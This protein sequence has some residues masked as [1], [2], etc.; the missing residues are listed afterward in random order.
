MPLY[1]GWFFLTF[2]VNKNK[3]KIKKKKRKKNNA[4]SD[5]V[6]KLML[7]TKG[8]PGFIFQPADSGS[9]YNL[10]YIAKELTLSVFYTVF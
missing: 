4:Y 10:V 6:I 2:P 7:K 9:R 1:P 3:I 5:I 8:P